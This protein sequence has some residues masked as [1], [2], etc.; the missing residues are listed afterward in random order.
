MLKEK[1]REQKDKEAEIAKWPAVTVKA[2]VHPTPKRQVDVQK[3]K[4]PSQML[5]GG[6]FTINIESNL[7]VG[8][9][10]LSPGAKHELV[11]DLASSIAQTSKYCARVIF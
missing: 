10:V 11:K 3:Q 5:T 8:I 9:E 7:Q 1:E 4:Q 6:R 2:E